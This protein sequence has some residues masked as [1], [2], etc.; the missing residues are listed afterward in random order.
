MAVPDN[1]EICQI[2]QALGKI[3]NEAHD[4]ENSFEPH[5]RVKDRLCSLFHAFEKKFSYDPGNP[6]K[7]QGPWAACLIVREIVHLRPAE[8]RFGR[9]FDLLI[10][11]IRRFQTQAYSP[12]GT[13]MLEEDIVSFKKRMHALQGAV[14]G[15]GLYSSVS[16]VAAILHGSCTLSLFKMRYRA[17][18]F[19][20]IM[21]N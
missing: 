10:G 17:Q 21:D 14:L 12:E 6:I 18:V 20:L 2:L 8:E 5:V 7:S 4:K 1:E 13:Q 11:V 15:A 16:I 9:L 3:L 19:R